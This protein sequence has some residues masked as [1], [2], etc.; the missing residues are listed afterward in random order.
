[1]LIR[2]FYLETVI[3]AHGFT[4]K[5]LGAILKRRTNYQHKHKI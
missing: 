3:I 1:M 5:T 4:G 2:V